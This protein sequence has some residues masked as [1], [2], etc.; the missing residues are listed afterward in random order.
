[1]L[2]QAS[3]RRK[4]TGKKKIGMMKFLALTLYLLARIALTLISS[5]AIISC[6]QKDNFQGFNLVIRKFELASAFFYAS[7][8]LFEK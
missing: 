1:M 2:Q 8:E 4:R 3:C 6:F 7:C 5:F